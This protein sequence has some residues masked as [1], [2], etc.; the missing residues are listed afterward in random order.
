M[1]RSQGVCCIVYL[2]PADVVVVAVERPQAVDGPPRGAPWGERD[3]EGDERPHPVGAEQAQVPRRE[4]AP[5]V[6]HHEHRLP[7]A[8][9]GVEERHQVAHDVH[10]RVL[11]LGGGRVG[12]AV[13]AQVGAT[14]RYPASA[15]ARIWW[16]QAYHTCGNPWRSSTGGAPGGPASATCI[17]RPLASTVRWVMTATSLSAAAAIASSFLA[18]ESAGG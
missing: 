2:D 5:V 11:Q 6:R 1:E 8:D 13:P 16:R 7:R 3:T 9:H 15:S 18:S 12:V 14:A 17:R 4:R 10:R